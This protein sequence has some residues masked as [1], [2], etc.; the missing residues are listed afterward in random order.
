MNW[1]NMMKAN[2]KENILIW[3]KHIPLTSLLLFSL[4]I[5]FAS[6]LILM[7]KLIPL[8][9]VSCMYRLTGDALQLIKFTLK[10][11]TFFLPPSIYFISLS[12]TNRWTCCYITRGFCNVEILYLQLEGFPLCFFSQGKAFTLNQF[13]FVYIHVRRS[14][15]LPC[16]CHN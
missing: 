2:T 13:Y 6:R 3:I 1:M 11:S 5:F 9:L 12:L 7:R 8:N 16:T 14:T 4:I 15:P 10:L